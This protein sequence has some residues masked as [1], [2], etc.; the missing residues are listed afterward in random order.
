VKG[1]RL[2]LLVEGQTELEFANKVLTPH[3][4]ASG[5]YLAAQ[6]VETSRRAE[7]GKRSGGGY[8]RKWRADLERLTK[9][10]PGSDVR[11]STLFDLYRLPEDFP[12][13]SELLSVRDTVRRAELAERGIAE[14]VGDRR[15]IPYV[16][17]HEFEA[18]VLTALEELRSIVDHPQDRVGLEALVREVGGAAPEDINDGP[19]SAPSK[20]L[21]RAV[22]SYQKPLHGPLV[23]QE[24]GLQKVR[25]RCERFSAWLERLESLPA[26]Q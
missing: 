12:G 13:I 1:V 11:F 15:L 3:L 25:S 26:E 9:S 5:V 14:A 16:Q 22:P 19:L 21:L 10:M 4:A 20:R 8:W 2:H 23:L 18:L 17:R 6:A 7:G 24:A